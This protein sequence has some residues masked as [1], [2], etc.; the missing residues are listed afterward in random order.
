M[1][2]PPDPAV[3]LPSPGSSGLLVGDEREDEI[4]VR[5]T[6]LVTLADAMKASL[7]LL[8]GRC[9]CCYS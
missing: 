8:L 5:H 3:A 6:Y 4:G 1:S 9:R 7:I 2:L